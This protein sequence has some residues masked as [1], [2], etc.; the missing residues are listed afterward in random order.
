MTVTTAKTVSKS[1]TL[2]ISPVNCAPFGVNSS[3]DRVVKVPGFLKESALQRLLRVPLSIVYSL[4]PPRLRHAAKFYLST[5]RSWLAGGTAKPSQDS[6]VPLHMLFGGI[7]S[8]VT[9]E[10]VL[11]AARLGFF[12]ESHAGPQKWWTLEERMVVR[13]NAIHINK[14]LR[15]QIR[16]SGFSFTLD[17]NFEDVVRRC[18]E[19]RS[20]RP[21][22][23]W[24]RPQ[25]AQLYGQLFDLGYA[26]SFEVWSES[27]ELVGG[28]YGL[29]IGKVFILES[30]FHGASHASKIGLV[31]LNHHLDALG[32]VVN[33]AKVFGALYD[34]LGYALT[35]SDDYENQLRQAASEE[36]DQVG[37]WRFDSDLEQISRWGIPAE[38]STPATP[39]RSARGS[40]PREAA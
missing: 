26:H 8:D 30:M 32:F 24:I 10:A 12:L 5:A 20:G 37:K 29:A 7:A 9:P 19:P 33:D 1:N 13:P 2:P 31:A 17:Q 6:I 11:S 27:G 15:S 35:D 22:F 39:K 25:L 28:G 16:N 40:N 36:F 38:P 21:R 23:T 3:R 18:A 34:R 14:R 4:R